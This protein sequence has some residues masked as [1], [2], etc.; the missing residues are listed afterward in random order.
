MK[1]LVLQGHS[2]PIKDIKFST[3][4]D[5]IFTASN[6]R[7]VIMWNTDTGDKLNTFPHAAAVNI[8]TLTCDMKYL[9]SGDNT[10]CLYIWDITQTICLIKLQQDPMYC[11]R[12]IDLTINDYLIMILYAS[13]IKN[14]K[15]FVYVYKLQDILSIPYLI[16]IKKDE[17]LIKEP[18]DYF[19]DSFDLKKSNSSKNIEN[20]NINKSNINNPIG[21]SNNNNLKQTKFPIEID[22]SKNNSIYK[23]DLFKYIECKTKETKYVKAKFSSLN[24][25][26]LI[27]REDGFLELINF[28]NGKLI[29]ENKFHDDIIFDFDIDYKNGIILTASRDGY[30]S[31]INFDTFELISKFHPLNPTLILNS[32]KIINLENPYFDFESE[33]KKTEMFSI[34]NINNYVFNLF[35]FNPNKKTQEIVNLDIDILFNSSYIEEEK[36][37]FGLSTKDK[38]IGFCFICGGQDS[39]L[40]TTTNQK[41]GGFDVLVYNTFTGEE[42]IKFQ[43]HFGPIN[44]LA[45]NQISKLLASGAEDSTI[46]IYKLE[47]YLFKNNNFVNEKIN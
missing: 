28:N 5:I 19:F 2:R 47:K 46:R 30:S 12:S 32:C 4:G 41:E 27:S 24:K 44:T 33:K 29:T 16:E 40:V 39:K 21:I 36:K 9:I 20:L 38:E 6:D 17:N 26:L 45:C 11:I 13:R 3:K 8:I 42:I 7:N 35:N 15:S 14:S 37:S 25:C 43:D 34:N 31:I 18:K 23:L 10:G 22:I 1:P